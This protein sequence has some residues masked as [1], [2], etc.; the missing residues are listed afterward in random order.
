MDK[1]LKNI[2]EYKAKL[3]LT[4][5]QCAEKLHLDIEK[6]QKIENNEDVE[7]TKDEEV[8]VNQEIEKSKSVPCLTG[9]L[10]CCLITQFYYK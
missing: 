6:M 9:T 10:F 3:N 2:L 4:T 7:I 5:E 8:L 1:L